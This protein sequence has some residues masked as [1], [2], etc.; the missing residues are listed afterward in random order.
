MKS[1]LLK[2]FCPSG[3][4]S[5]KSI[6]LWTVLSGGI[7]AASSFVYLVIVTQY[8]DA[9]V[10]GIF[11]IAMAVSQQL[12]TIGWFNTRKFQVSDTA[13]GYSIGDYVCARVI[14]VSLMLAAGLAWIMLGDFSYE[15]RIAAL[16]LT[17]LKA[18]EAFSD[19]FAGRYQQKNRFD[20]ACRILFAKTLATIVVFY[21][22]ITITS[23]L[24]L[25]LFAMLAVHILMTVIIDGA[26]MPL[27][28]QS[29]IKFSLHKSALLLL[30][31]LPLFINSFLQMY[32]NNAS[33]Y[34]VDRYCSEQ[35][36][37]AYGVLSMV[38]FVVAL[39]ADFVINPQIASVAKAYNSGNRAQF[40][41][42][43]LRQGSIVIL[44]GVF[45]LIAA[46]F[47]GI[48]V[49]SFCFGFDLGNNAN[50]LCVLLIAGMLLALYQIFQL[51]LI[52][53][54]KQAWCILG[55]V[56][57]AVA[58]F[59]S[60]SLFVKEYG[61]IGGAFSYLLS[62]AILLI[63][64]AILSITFLQRSKKDDICC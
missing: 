26:I 10:G 19:V 63:I 9:Y 52:V 46:R 2:I 4:I 17:A 33:K 49:L 40:I 44:I 47:V 45:G 48:P 58:A 43:M 42:T 7:Y 12:I 29:G 14:S 32:L 16:L 6:A 50:A 36:M 20:V 41:G 25:S 11:S 5:P 56:A 15:K 31:C 24:N 53:I 51:I 23:N 21:I 30:A 39:L 1:L 37:A 8:L 60:S 28:S 3:F 34:A 13:E 27:Y 54:R 61:I 35:E 55:I 38:T 64:F 62:M 22:C 18:S 59:F 57:S